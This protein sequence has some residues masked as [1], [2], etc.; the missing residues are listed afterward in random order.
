MKKKKIK[1][2]LFLS[3]SSQTKMIWD[4]IVPFLVPGMAAT[5]SGQAHQDPLGSVF[6]NGFNH[7]IGTGWPKTA[8]RRKGRGN[9]ALVKSN[10]RYQ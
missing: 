5:N 3:I 2:L 9:K 6:F 4:W 1:I 8:G 7:V 10:R